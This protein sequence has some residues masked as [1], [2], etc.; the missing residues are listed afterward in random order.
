MMTKSENMIPHCLHT[1]QSNKIE[2]NLY[3][4]YTSPIFNWHECAVRVT[5]AFVLCVCLSV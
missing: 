1:I 4:D 5:T 3:Y 2:T